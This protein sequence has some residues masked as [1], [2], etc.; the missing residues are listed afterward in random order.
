MAGNACVGFHTAQHDMC[1]D[2]VDMRMDMCMDMC[3]NMFI[4]MCIDMCIVLNSHVN[5]V[6][7]V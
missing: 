1:M 2:S 5:G 4:C 3:I 6:T 7:C